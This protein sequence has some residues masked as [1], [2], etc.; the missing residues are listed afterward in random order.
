MCTKLQKKINLLL[1][2]VIMFYAQDVFLTNV[3][4]LM[5]YST[6]KMKD[7]SVAGKKYIDFFIIEKKMQI[8]FCSLDINE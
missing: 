7:L 2:N 4:T 5:A 8:S 1:N 6:Q 3:N